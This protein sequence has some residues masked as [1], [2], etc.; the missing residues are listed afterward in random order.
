[1]PTNR[2]QYTSEFKLK[3]VLESLQRDTTI[4]TVRKK[5]DVHNTQIN[6]WWSV[7]WKKAGKVATTIFDSP[8]KV[9]GR[10]QG[11]VNPGKSPEELTR[12]IGQLTIENEILKKALGSF[13]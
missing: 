11:E 4:E 5:F 1:M 10:G 7:F 2:K 8:S 9:K 3:V 6:S 12:L 13:T